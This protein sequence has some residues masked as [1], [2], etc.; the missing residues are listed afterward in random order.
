EASRLQD[1]LSAYSCGVARV[2]RT[3]VR[4]APSP[5]GHAR[6]PRRLRQNAALGGE[7][8]TPAVSTAKTTLRR[9]MNIMR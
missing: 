6:K 8:P 7:N 2:G 1:R 5:S 9:Y 3:A 4:N